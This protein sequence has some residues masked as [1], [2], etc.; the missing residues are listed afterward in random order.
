MEPESTSPRS[1][2][3]SASKRL[4]HSPA[5]LPSPRLPVSV[6]RYHLEALLYGPH[7]ESPHDTTNH[8]HQLQLPP[9]ASCDPSDGLSW[10]TIDALSPILF[11]VVLGK[12]EIL[13]FRIFQS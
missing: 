8:K 3:T 4:Y 13:V 5:A 11:R 10:S 1:K 12:C 7:I 9:S 2:V 6:E